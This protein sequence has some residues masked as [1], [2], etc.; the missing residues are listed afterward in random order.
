VL[1][2]SLGVT[3]QAYY[4]HWKHQT[5]QGYEQQVVVQLVKKIRLEHPAIGT[6]KLH[7]M[8][9]RD[10]V[11]HSIKMG[12]DKLYDVMA[13]EGLLLRKRRWRVQTTHSNHPYNKY[14][15]LIIGMP[16]ERPNQLWVSDITYWKVQNRFWYLTFIT[17]AYS[18]KIVGYKL[19][20]NLEAINNVM[21][22]GMAISNSR[23]SLAGLVH[24]SDRGIQYCTHEYTR[25]LRANG[26]HISMTQSGDP[27]ENPIAERINGIIKNEYLNHYT[28]NDFKEAEVLV[29]SVVERYNTERPHL[30]CNLK[31]PQ[32]IHSSETSLLGKY[33]LSTYSRNKEYV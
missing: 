23:G 30:S 5:V 31:V 1:S 20:R 25:M 14:P 13:S 8:I 18:K 2:R 29:A 21:A 19:A 7:E 16:L 22:L 9:N 4:Q 10:L 26:I 17:D 32:A 6:R 28:V 3:R 33:N 11:S 12:R 27:L 24:H 15:N